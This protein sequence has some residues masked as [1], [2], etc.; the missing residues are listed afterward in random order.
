MIERRKDMQDQFDRLADMM[1][2]N[3]TETIQRL[4]VI[5]TNQK[6]DR[7]DISELQAQCGQHERIV[8]GGKGIAWLLTA[9]GISVV[10]IWQWMKGK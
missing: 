4:T 9:T 3:H 2:K 1:G 5:E 6:T 7:E 8:A 10:G